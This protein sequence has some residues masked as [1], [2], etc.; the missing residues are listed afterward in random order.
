ME[1]KKDVQKEVES[2]LSIVGVN[3]QVSVDESDEQYNVSVATEENALLIGKH[4]NTLSSLELILSII[5]AKKTGTYK[6]VVLEVGGYRKERE[7]YLKTLA[8]RLKDEVLETGAEKTIRGL[9]PWERR[10]I[11][12][13]FSE[14]PEVQTESQGDERER[15]L[16]IKKRSEATP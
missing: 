8:S 7:E 15:I 9:K 16:I 5:L 4:G 6:R 3:G 14:D 12:L 2:L 1:Q 11:H 10:L 13:E